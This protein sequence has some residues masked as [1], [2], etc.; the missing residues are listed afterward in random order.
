MIIIWINVKNLKLSFFLDKEEFLI[1]EKNPMYCIYFYM[2]VPV[3]LTRYT[4]HNKKTAKYIG[5]VL[6]GL[7]KEYE[8]KWH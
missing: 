3:P 5:G 2:H 7:K 6:E 4:I 8:E 1:K